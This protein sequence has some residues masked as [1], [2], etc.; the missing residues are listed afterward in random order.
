[1]TTKSKQVDNEIITEMAE[2]GVLYSHKKSKAD[3]RMKPFVVAN[4]YQLDVLDAGAVL[5]SIEKAGEFMKEILSNDGTILFV[6]TTAVSRE[7]VKEL[8]EKLGQPYVVNRWL[9]G[10][11]TNLD[12]IKKRIKHYLELKEKRAEGELE[13][14]TKKEQVEFDKE[15]DQ[16]TRKFDGIK[17][18]K[19]IPDAVFV[20]NTEKHPIAVK[21]SRD[22][23][24]P[25]IGVID[26]NDNPEEVD[27]PIIAND[28]AKSSLEWVMNKLDE[29]IVISDVESKKDDVKNKQDE[30]NEK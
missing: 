23:D 3:P 25:V 22:K 5:D 7:Q 11:L 27:Y 26:T 21:E 1:M 15:I 14:Y 13:K 24:V 9:G 28:H 17:S 20:I 18:L 4:R 10:T 16:L 29:N 6:G 30:N 8:A 19:K 12:V 2:A